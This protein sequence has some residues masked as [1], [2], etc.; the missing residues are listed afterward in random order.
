MY[1]DHHNPSEP[2]QA[3][4][5]SVDFDIS[6]RYMYIGHIDTSSTTNNSWIVQYDLGVTWDSLIPSSSVL[7]NGVS[8]DT[9]R[10]DNR[11]GNQFATTPYGKLLI[12]RPTNPAYGVPSF[13]PLT[14]AMIPNPDLIFGW[15][16]YS[17]PDIPIPGGFP[18]PC[19]RYIDSP[20]LATGLG[21]RAVPLAVVGIWP[22]PMID[23]ATLVFNGSAHPE[24]VI[25]RD[26][27][28][29]VVRRTAVGQIGPTYILEREGLPAGLYMVEVL[30]S[31]GTL[32]VVKV[33]CE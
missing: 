15:R 31:K 24:S 17:I 10:Y 26:A 33:L 27:L 18:A 4:L 30:G 19:K 2:I 25:W 22:N 8:G 14:E 20:P 13:Q 9:L 23:F 1:Y 12:R 11:F 28:G 3:L 21:H 29:R 5:Q 6:G 7:T 32:G 16:Y